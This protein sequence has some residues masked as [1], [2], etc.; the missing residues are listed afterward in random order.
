MRIFFNI[1]GCR[2]VRF[3]FKFY[4]F[5]QGV[6]IVVKVLQVVVDCIFRIFICRPTC[7][8]FR[9][10]R[11]RLREIVIPTREGIARSRRFGLG[12]EIIF[13]DYL[14]LYA[15]T[16]V[17]VKGYFIHRATA[18]GYRKQFYVVANHFQN[19][20]GII[21]NLQIGGFAVNGRSAILVVIYNVGCIAFYRHFVNKG[22]I[23]CSIAYFAVDFSA[24]N[25]KG[26]EQNARF[27][28]EHVTANGA[29]LGRGCRCRCACHVPFFAFFIT[30]RAFVPM[31][32][33]V[34]RPFFCVF[35]GELVD[36][37]G[38]CCRFANRTGISRFAFFSA[39]RGFGYFAVIPS[40]YARCRGLFVGGIIATIS[41][42]SY[43]FFPAELGTSGGFCRVSF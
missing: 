28:L 3:A 6:I 30:A 31:V 40:M 11:N 27:H 24:V 34:A 32:C 29:G 25:S 17:C 8:D 13:F 12:C 14:F 16:A 42:A 41:L 9:G 21:A 23:N 43:V 37:L 22:K 36:R 4:G 2:R 19:V 5:M 39:G 33:F 7:R 15:R 20:E 1:R 26:F 18:N 38:F 10:L 35:V